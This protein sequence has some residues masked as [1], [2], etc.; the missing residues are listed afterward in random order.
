MSAVIL[1]VKDLTVSFDGFK[2]VGD[3][4][5]ESKKTNCA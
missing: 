3:L 5:L 4:D 1:S 2:A